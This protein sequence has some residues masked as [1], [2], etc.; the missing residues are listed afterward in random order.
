MSR[1]FPRLRGT[2]S[3]AVAIC[4]LI[5]AMTTA[6]TLA[7]GSGGD[8][9]APD[10][11]GENSPGSIPET[12]VGSWK[13]EQIGDVV[14]DPATGQC[15]SSFVRS[16]TLEL[17]AQGGFTHVLVYE[18]HL[19]GCDLEVL[20]QS[21]GTAEAQDTTLLLH[22]SDGTTRVQ[23]SC[24]ES[25]TTDESGNTDSYRW[26]L[27]ETDAGVQQLTLIDEDENTLGPFDRQ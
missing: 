26:D 24:G 25:G 5:A 19:G 10:G 22:I 17:T 6:L 23:N 14:C 2:G 3:P 18:S 12:L 20:H 7:C 11:N 13:W 9:A 21:E 16:Q 4:S 15:S 1:P 27:S 8:A